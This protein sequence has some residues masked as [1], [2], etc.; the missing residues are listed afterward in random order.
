MERTLEDEMRLRGLAAW[1]VEEVD[2]LVPETKK[3]L[4]KPDA[5][6]GLSVAIHIVCRDAAIRKRLGVL[7]APFVQ[8]VTR[9]EEKL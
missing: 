6:F 3:R 8:S 1:L 7:A 2:G 9:K 4:A 5:L